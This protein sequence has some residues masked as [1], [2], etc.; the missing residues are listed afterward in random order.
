MLGDMDRRTLLA[1]VAAT[2]LASSLVAMAVA[3]RRRHAFDVPF[4]HGDSNNVPRESFLT[5]TAMSAPA[6]ML[7]TQAAAIAVLVRRPSLNAV[8]VIGLL[9]V[10]NV[11]GY[12]SER[13]VRRR[14]SPSGWDR[15]ESPL[16]L[17]G[18]L[19]AAAMALLARAMSRDS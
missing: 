13:L 10:V 11:P 15:L 5:G 16:I 6:F 12:L 3:I 18:I 17:S 1:S 19:P 14:L 4:L 8:R 2:H 9:G 7:A